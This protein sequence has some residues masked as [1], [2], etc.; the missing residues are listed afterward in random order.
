MINVGKVAMVPLSNIEVGERAREVMGD[1]GHMEGSMKER[2][3]IT[4][5]AVKELDEGKFFLL[6]GE[7]RF[8]VLQ[9]NKVESVPVRVF[10]DDIDD[11]EMKSIELAENMYRKDFEYWEY[12]N[13]VREIHELQQSIH[14]EKAPGPG[15]E[16]WGTNETGE[17]LNT[18]KASVSTAIKRANAREAFPQLF[19]KCKTQKDA[20]KIIAGME[21]TIIK[22]VVAQKIE[23]EIQ[24]IRDP[25]ESKAVRLANSYM[26]GDFFKGVKAIDDGVMHLVEIDPPYGIDLR[27]AKKEETVTGVELDVYNEVDSSEYQVFL[28]N[29]FAECYR[30]MSKHSWLLCW[31]APEPWFEIVYQELNNAG[32]TTTRMCGIWNK[33]YG[34]SK[35][36]EIHLANSYE[37]FFYAWKGRP[38]LNKPGR[39]NSFEFSPVP[40]NQKVHPTERP[41]DLMKEIYD[42]FACVGS[43]VLIPFLGS[44]SG[45]LAADELGMTASG[46]ELAKE[47]RD[48]FLLKI[49]S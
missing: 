27:K 25:N 8:L 13:L 7:R 20:S 38:A 39:A 36:P 42:T 17:L 1:L 16:G 33:G 12:D 15:S 43:R 6:A 46:F 29:L 14:G 28:A 22:E 23:S 18:T 30:V 34:Q 26:L 45:I 47:Y 49:Y 4:P 37:M 48:S 31:F 44:G 10:P 9:K 24:S 40:P 2:G 5:L 19:D 11:I 21:D 3:L 35:R 32:F 41:I